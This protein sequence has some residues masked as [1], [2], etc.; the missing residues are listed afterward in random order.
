MKRQL[1][2]FYAAFGDSGIMFILYAFSV[3]V[4]TL[5]TWNMEL[6]AVYPDEI[7]AAGTAAYFAG[8]DWSSLIKTIGG[9]GYIQAIIYVPVFSLFSSPYAIYKAMLVVNS[10]LV[11]FIPLIVYHLAAKL[12]IVRVRHKLMISLSCGMYV[13]YIAGSKFIW[14]ESITSLLC[15]VMVL[16]VFTAW[17]RKNKSARFTMSILLGFL[18]AVS[19]AANERLIA[20]TAAIL[21]TVLAAH[22]IFRE[23]VLNLAA[24]AISAVLSFAA[25]YFVNAALRADLWGDSAGLTLTSSA[26]GFFGSFYSG[27]YAFMTTTFG[28][29]ALAAALFVILM[30]SLIRE[31]IRR[32]VDT[33][34]SNTKVYE[35][36]KHKYSIRLTLFALFQFLTIGFTE[37]FTSLFPAKSSGLSSFVCCGENAAP[38][39]LFLVLTFIIQYGIDLKKLL[40]AVGIYAYS[41]LC[42]AAAGYQAP[43]AEGAEKS[44][45]SAILPLNGSFGIGA[46]PMTY[47]I[48]S[49]CVFSLYALLIVLVSC[50]RKHR[51]ALTS[52][53]IFTVCV[54]SC[55]AISTVYVPAVGRQNAEHTAP[56]CDVFALLYNTPQSPPIVAYETE[57]EL[58]GLIQFLAPDTP[59]SLLSG[60]DK[61]PESCLLIAKNG[62]QLPNSAGSYDNVGKTSAY[63]VYAFGETARDFIRYSSAQSNQSNQSNP[64]N[65]SNQSNQLNPPV[66]PVTLL[67]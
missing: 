35:P 64:S 55:G 20:L 21:V 39:A 56:Y 32:R 6:P 37:L 5:L 19:Y 54:L 1:E 62:V 25:E 45:L 31:G 23:K 30:L 43:L 67:K 13:T 12:G 24:F 2:H 14:N 51:T 3:V 40:L 15:W 7:S 50:S 60:N 59:V 61:I 49:S 10:L 66:Y 48:I 18:C 36:I 17:D 28:M 33:P 38:F 34:E 53:M 9:D 57:P 47:L 42:F 8:K 65:Q 11:S 58:A 63:T 52:V 4:N 27:I 44:L 29:G 22:F 16:C 26:G 46:S 41:C